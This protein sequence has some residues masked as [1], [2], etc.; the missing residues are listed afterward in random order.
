AL[1]FGEKAAI[2]RAAGGA[3]LPAVHFDPAASDIE[4]FETGDPA[5][6]AKPQSDAWWATPNRRRHPKHYIEYLLDPTGEM[7]K[8][9]K[10]REHG[11]RALASLDWQSVVT[12]PVHAQMVR[13]FL[14]DI[15]DMIGATLPWCTSGTCHPLME[16]KR[17]GRLRNIG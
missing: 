3:V 10:E 12:T 13:A 15:A 16:R 9:Y 5:Y 2:E 6:L 1:F 7:G 8:G 17:G 4:R 14:D 11:K